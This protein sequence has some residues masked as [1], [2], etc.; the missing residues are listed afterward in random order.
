MA[1]TKKDKVGYFFFQVAIVIVYL[2]FLVVT[3]LIS[4][5]ESKA[6]KTAYDPEYFNTLLASVRSDAERELL[7]DYYQLDTADNTMKTIKNLKLKDRLMINLILKRNNKA[8]QIRFGIYFLILTI[9]YFTRYFIALFYKDKKI[10][11]HF[12]PTVAVIVPVKNEE[13]HIFKTIEHCYENGYPLDKLEVIVINDGS[14]DNTLQEIKRAKSCY[15]SLKYKSYT[16]NRGKRMA[17]AAAVKLTEAQFFIMLDSDTLLEKNAVQQVLQHFSDPKV[18]AISGHTKVANLNENMLTKAQGFKYFCSYRLF[19]AFEG[20][21]GTVVCAPGC[22]SAYRADKFREIMEEWHSKTFFGRRCIAGE[23]RALTTLLLRNNKIKYSNE[24][25]AYTYV[26]TTLKSFAIQQKRW[27]RSWFR[28][29]LYVSRFMWRKN[30]LPAISFYFMLFIST[31]APITLFRECFI[32]PL[33]ILRTPWF[34]LLSLFIIIFT[35]AFF[36]VL[37]KKSGF[38]LY[39]FLFSLLYFF[40]LVWLIPVSIFTVTSGNW[41]SRGALYLPANLELAE[42]EIEEKCDQ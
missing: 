10:D 37:T 17:I 25:V 34:Y 32:M 3:P 14:T 18:A 15:P 2:F 16:I 22:F 13:E 4:I 1:L 24:A 19:K 7:S 31:F 41:G 11:P 40:F 8:V 27:M 30:P 39:G 12:L 42:S 29:S 21:F 20:V 36:C 38:F 28:E 33:L 23:D 6:I 9:L 26:P 35:Q 5:L